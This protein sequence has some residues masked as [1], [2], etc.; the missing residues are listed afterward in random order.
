MAYGS[1]AAGPF[2]AEAQ[3]SLLRTCCATNARLG[4]TGVLLY[5]NGNFLQVLEGE[6]GVVR[7]LYLRIRLDPRHTGCITLLDGALDARMFPASLMAFHAGAD[8]SDEDRRAF[9]AFELRARA[10]T[11]GRPERVVQ[12]LIEVFQRIMR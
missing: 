4:V 1:A 11:A 9:D 2:D 7:D 12:K 5:R 3:A 6:E 10:L 8:L